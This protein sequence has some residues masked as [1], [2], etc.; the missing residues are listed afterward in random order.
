MQQLKKMHKKLFI[1][2][3]GLPARG[4]TH[5]AS[6][7]HRYLSWLGYRSEIFTF[8]S[9]LKKKGIDFNPVNYPDDLETE[10][11]TEQYTINVLRELVEFLKADGEVLLSLGN[12]FR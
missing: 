2:M 9:I 12:I 8:I 4:K 3:V 7:M 6:K 5:I 11:L 10:N 1:G